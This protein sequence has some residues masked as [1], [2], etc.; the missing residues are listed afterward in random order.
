MPQTLARHSGESCSWTQTIG[1]CW[2]VHVQLKKY[3]FSTQTTE[4][5][6]ARMP[7][8]GLVRIQTQ[9][10][11]DW[12]LRYFETHSIACCFWFLGLTSFSSSF[13]P[14]YYRY[15]LPRKYSPLSLWTE[16]NE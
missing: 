8:E 14:S 7:R 3:S 4:V 1:V 10:G 2:A 15:T 6:S 9:A 16:E 13:A 5:G 11:M 12:Y